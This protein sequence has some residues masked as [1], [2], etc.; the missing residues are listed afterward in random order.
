MM[1]QTKDIKKIAVVLDSNAFFIPF[2]FGIDISEGLEALLKTNFETL[3]LSPVFA[4]LRRLARTGSP[5]MKRNATYALELAKEC[6]FV[7]VEQGEEET[8]DIITEISRKNGWLV[9]TNDRHLR[10]RLR[11]I[12]VPVIYVR[13]KS[14]LEIDG[15]F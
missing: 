1:S 4:E 5:K 3:L 13:N 15:R 7:P 11:N 9:F 14:R 2:Q 12:N 10:K 8:D 6:R